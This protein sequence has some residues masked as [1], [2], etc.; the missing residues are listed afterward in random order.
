MYKK[1]RFK[2]GRSHE[3]KE[4]KEKKSK[5]RKPKPKHTVEGKKTKMK[6]QKKSKNKWKTIRA[7][8]EPRSEG[9]ATGDDP[10]MLISPN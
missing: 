3:K 6:K 10:V 1:T 2:L 5:Q 9:N 7:K 4:R 8:K